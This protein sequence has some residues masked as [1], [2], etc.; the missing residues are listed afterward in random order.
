MQSGKFRV[1]K[2][3]T[4]SQ[5]FSFFRYTDMINELATVGEDPNQFNE[6]GEAPLCV[7]ADKGLGMVV[8]EL[9]QRDNIKVN[10]KGKHGRTP[11]YIAAEGGH[12]FIVKCLL[13]HPNID[14]NSR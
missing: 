7:A 1:E 12:V 5:G 3:G 10:I 11:L 2:H 9:L 4:F 8:A 13:R 6:Y 14:V